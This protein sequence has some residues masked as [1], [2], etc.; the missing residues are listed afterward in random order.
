[1]IYKRRRRWCNMSP[2]RQMVQY[3]PRPEAAPTTPRGASHFQRTVCQAPSGGVG[4]NLWIT[5]SV[6]HKSA[7]RLTRAARCYQS[8][9]GSN[10]P[11][12][13]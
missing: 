8:R 1:M 3:E 11:I 6:V 7:N 9:L 12:V 13:S 10:R 2:V 4:G 5:E